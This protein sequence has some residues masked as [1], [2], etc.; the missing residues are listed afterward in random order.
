MVGERREKFPKGRF[1]PW[2]EAQ[3]LPS[4]GSTE[5]RV[6]RA[7]FLLGLNVGTETPTPVATIYEM[8]SNWEARMFRGCEST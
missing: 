7:Q 8:A 2:A 1:A 3:G 6:Y 4:P 5:P